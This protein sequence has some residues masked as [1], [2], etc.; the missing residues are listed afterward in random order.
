ML[1]LQ[2]VS[3]D[4]LLNRTLIVDNAGRTSGLG[5]IDDWEILSASRCWV[6]QEDADQFEQIRIIGHAHLATHPQQ[7]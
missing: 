7:W 3:S 5:E 1:L 6:A 4:H 2:D